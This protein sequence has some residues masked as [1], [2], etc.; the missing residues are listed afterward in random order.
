M[1]FALELNEPIVLAALGV[2]GIVGA[3]VILFLIAGLFG[4]RSLVRRE[5]SA[6]FL[7]P[8]AYVVLVV[9]LLVLGCRFYLTL[10]QLTTAGPRGTEFPMQFMFN[11][12]SAEGESLTFSRSRL[13]ELLSGVAL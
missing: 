6:Y 8:V 4:A 12:L 3:L 10:D 11:L 13:P 7:S 1:M 9:F 5:F 2:A